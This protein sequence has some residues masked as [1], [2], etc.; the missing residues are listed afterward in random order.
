M[1]QATFVSAGVGT[2]RATSAGLR[3]IPEPMIPPITIIVAEKRPS[4][5]A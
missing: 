4:R 3:K 5:R 2:I 1:P